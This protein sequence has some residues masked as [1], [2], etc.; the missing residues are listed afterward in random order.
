MSNNIEIL[1]FFKWDSL[2]K[3]LFIKGEHLECYPKS[4][5]SFEIR[6]K[7]FDY[8]NVFCKFG[9]TK[10]CDFYGKDRHS[11]FRLRVTKTHGDNCTIW[12]ENG[13]YF[14]SDF[15]QFL[16]YVSEHVPLLKKYVGGE[17]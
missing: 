10:F 11:E 13:E 8:H 9:D 15:S 2:G 14:V 3:T 4:F 6:V 17:F 7:Y 16:D 12:P 5:S 1:L